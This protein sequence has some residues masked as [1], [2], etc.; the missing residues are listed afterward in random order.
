[1]RR[2]AN[3]HGGASSSDLPAQLM[4]LIVTHLDDLDFARGQPV[5]FARRQYYYLSPSKPFTKILACGL[6]LASGSKFSKPGRPRAGPYQIL[7]LRGIGGYGV[8]LP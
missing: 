1:M 3:A 2:H 8:N 5:G 7:A 6:N 4:E